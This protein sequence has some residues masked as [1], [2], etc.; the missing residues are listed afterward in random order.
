[1]YIETKTDILADFYQSKAFD[2]IMENIIK[3][4]KDRR[5]KEDFRQDLMITLLEKDDDLIIDLYNNGHLAYYV[6]RIIQNQIIS[7]TSPFHRKYRKLDVYYKAFKLEDKPE[8]HYSEFDVLKYSN[9]NRILSWYETEM[10]C[11][12]YKMGRHSKRDGKVS[13]RTIEAEY[14]IDH[15]SIYT[16][17]KEAVRKLR[18]HIEENNTKYECEEELAEYLKTP[19]ISDLYYCDQSGVRMLWSDIKDYKDR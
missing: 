5:F 16:T 4:K 7:S 1:M 13:Y 3:N 19:E 8:D 2:N 9:E 6:T 12:Y 17:V 18:E 15:C 10:L 14:G 11:F